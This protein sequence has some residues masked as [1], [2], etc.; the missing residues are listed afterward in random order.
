MNRWLLT[1][2]AMVCVSCAH[3]QTVAIGDSLTVGYGVAPTE[4]YLKRIE[5]ARGITI[6]NKGVNGSMV[7]DRTA[8][9][10]ARVINAT[11]CSILW[12]GNNDARIYKTNAIK[13]VYFRD[14]LQALAAWLALPLK[15]TARASGVLTGTWINTT[16]YGIGKASNVKGS[17]I[18][19]TAYGTAV[20]LSV[21]QQNAAGRGTADVFIDGNLKGSFATYTP[22]P[23]TAKNIAYGPKLLRFANLENGNHEI[24]V[25]VTSPTLNANYVYVDWAAGNDQPSRPKVFVPEPIF[26]TAAGYAKYGGSTANSTDFRNLV[27]S[28]VDELAIDG[29]AVHRVATQP[30]LNLAIDMLADGVHPTAAG[31][32][33]LATA[34][35]DV[36]EPGA[37][38]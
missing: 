10:Y 38:P 20:Y 13:R 24:K 15:Q 35:L 4:G 14:G 32:T 8:D 18:T 6:V 27:V 11:S 3:A 12:M 26:M 16:A 17:T 7:P 25:V 31:H 1:A 2:L 19:L 21:I 36:M 22:L 30:V 28:A 34:I 23:N 33:K 9:A 29:L 5:A 37:C